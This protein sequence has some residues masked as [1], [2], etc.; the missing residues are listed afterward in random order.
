ML[1]PFIYFFNSYLFV[2]NY[3]FSL[4]SMIILS[5]TWSGVK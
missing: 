3:K 2:S 1:D 4:K 5:D